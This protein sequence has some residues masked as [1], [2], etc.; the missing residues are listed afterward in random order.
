MT[1]RL[2]NKLS[3][4]RPQ[5]QEAYRNGATLRQ[6]AEV[7]GVSAGT[8]RNVLVEMGELMR[9]RGRRK[10][11]DTRDPRILPVDPVEELEDED[12][13]NRINPEGYEGGLF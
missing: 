9:A 8:V 4:V 11:A 6:I 3:T 1:T 5:V 13:A 12:D 10:K 7:Y 2:K